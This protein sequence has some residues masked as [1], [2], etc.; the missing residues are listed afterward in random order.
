[1]KMTLL[2]GFSVAERPWWYFLGANEEMEGF[3]G[4]MLK[5]E[6]QSEV[7]MDRTG[8]ST[9]YSFETV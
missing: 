3:F 8:N 9:Q 7:P 4:K 2:Q 1:M 5:R 6:P